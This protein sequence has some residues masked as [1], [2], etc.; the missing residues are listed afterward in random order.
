MIFRRGF[1]VICYE[2]FS[3]KNKFSP[4]MWLSPHHYWTFCFLP[5]SI[6]Q[7]FA[8]SGRNVFHTLFFWIKNFAKQ[9]VIKFE[10]RRKDKGRWKLLDWRISIVINRL[11]DWLIDRLSEWVSD[12]LI[13]WLTGWWFSPAGGA[14]EFSCHLRRFT[15]SKIKSL[16]YQITSVLS[17]VCFD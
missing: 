17:N 7:I 15:A 12:W 5:C 14:V 1:L 2:Q 6:F 16:I 10:Q 3:K 4:R 13:D 11:I 8:I 9:K